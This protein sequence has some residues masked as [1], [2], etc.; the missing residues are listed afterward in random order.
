M[1]S[2]IDHEND[3]HMLTWYLEDDMYKCFIFCLLQASSLLFAFLLFYDEQ[4][5]CSIIVLS[6]N[7]DTPLLHYIILCTQY[8]KLVQYCI[9][10]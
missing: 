1:H 8:I 3:L 5:L 10:I 4:N 2:Y 7:N 9:C 6:S